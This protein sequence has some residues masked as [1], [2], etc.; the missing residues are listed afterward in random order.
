MS[1]NVSQ[2]GRG[3]VLKNKRKKTQKTFDKSCFQEDDEDQECGGEG[4]VEYVE[5]DDE[6][7]MKNL[8]VVEFSR[9]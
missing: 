7:I 8:Q 2:R 6:N 3:A 5:Q 4:G 9:E 1:N